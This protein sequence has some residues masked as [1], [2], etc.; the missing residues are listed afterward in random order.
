MWHYR[1][2]D[3]FDAKTET[4]QALAGAGA[5]VT[6]TIASDGALLSASPRKQRPCPAI[7]CG[8]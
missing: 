4:V 1:L 3:G 5:Y 2:G 6:S 7:R 8:C